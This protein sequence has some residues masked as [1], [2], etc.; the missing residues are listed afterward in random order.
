MATTLE[1]GK[2]IQNFLVNNTLEGG[3]KIITENILTLKQDELRQIEEILE[4]DKYKLVFIGQFGSGKTT[5]INYLFDLTYQTEKK[6]EELLFTA[7]GKTTLCEVCVKPTK[8]EHSYFEINFVSEK[9]LHQNIK[10]FCIQI[11][12]RVNKE[13]DLAGGDIPEEYER[14][15][16][17]ITGLKR[18][19]KTSKDNAI[20]ALKKNKN[21]FNQFYNSV[22]EGIEVSVSETEVITYKQEQ[23]TLDIE[24]TN[25]DEK[26]WIQETYRKVNLASKKGFSIPNDFTIYI[27]EKLVEENSVFTKF[28]SIIDTRGITEPAK[29]NDNP[30]VRRDDLET[31]ILK[32]DTICIFTSD[33]K[34]APQPVIKHLIGKYYID[35]DDLFKDRLFTLIL[36]KKGEHFDVIVDDETGE[37]A[38]SW[39]DGINTQKQKIRD[40]FNQSNIHFNKKNI[41]FY[42]AKRHFENF[43]T[44][45]KEKYREI[46]DDKDNVFKRIIETIEIRQK[47]STKINKLNLNVEK[48]IKEGIGEEIEKH[49]IFTIKKIKEYSRLIENMDFS[50][51]FRLDYFDYHHMTMYA[52]HRR[53]GEYGNIKLWQNTKEIVRELVQEKSNTHYKRIIQ[54][55]N[56]LK[57]DNDSLIPLCKELETYASNLYR[58]F[59]WNLGDVFASK[60]QNKEFSEYSSLWDD[61]NDFWGQ[62]GGYKRKVLELMEKNL[63]SVDD[64]LAEAIENKWKTDFI[65]PILKFLGIDNLYK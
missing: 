43:K 19:N 64:S 33:F 48:I 36:P 35:R 47:L 2:K 1:I 62:G 23:K 39:E 40:R 22:I 25:T 61:L 28:H 18:D 15:I 49:L 58:N 24:K 55:I 34:P 45:K 60:I 27:S 16:R 46:R 21:D 29:N 52:I 38:N 4:I 50:N 37:Q 26:K 6:T 11:Y 13:T 32:P 17:N 42:D 12:N 59:Y 56:L 41:L 10:D 54:E 9:E 20:E 5:A 57:E 44:Q 65:D 53:Q 51:R 3:I 63:K 7:A 30:K 14:A 31:H 8:Q